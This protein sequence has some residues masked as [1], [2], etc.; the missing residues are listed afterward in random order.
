MEILRETK[1]RLGI[2]T[3]NR[4]VALNALSP[5]MIRDVTEALE[6]WESDESIAAVV[7]LGAGDRA[8]C[9][10]GDVKLFHAL[11]MA[12]RE[13]QTGIDVPAGYFREEYRMDSMIYHY[14]KP[15]IALMDGI[16]M[17][18]GFGIAGNCRYR[19]ATDKTVFAM[20]ESGIGFFPDVG[21]AYH[22]LKLPH[23]W[24]KYF[25]ITGVPANAADVMA[26]GLAD[27]YIPAIEHEAFIAELQKGPDIEKTLEALNRP[28]PGGS[29]LLVQKERIEEAFEPYSVR[30]IAK[31][32]EKNTDAWSQETFK[33][34]Q[35]RSPFS[36]AVTAEHMRRCE[37]QPFDFVIE[38]DLLLAH[39]FLDQPDLYEG[40]RAAVIDKDRKPNWRQEPSEAEVVACFESPLPSGRGLG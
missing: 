24:G 6:E 3:L 4:P 26:A 14:P 5:A 34:M 18:G 29:V 36:M 25:A 33:L 40:I 13:G 37:G 9:A 19:V 35:S 16:T 11:G 30:E 22:L 1:G 31:R 27:C 17:G 28:A 12:Y 32:L 10:G 21:S 38:Q 20:P 39:A 15:C 7:F 8:F 23:N 2:L